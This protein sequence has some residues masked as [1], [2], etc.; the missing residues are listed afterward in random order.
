MVRSGRVRKALA[1]GVAALLTA[2]TLTLL[3]V[4]PAHAAPPLWSVGT[5]E[6]IFTMPGSG[7]VAG[8]EVACAAGWTPIAGSHQAFGTGALYR[9]SEEVGYGSGGVYSVTLK[10]G[11]NNVATDLYVRAYCVPTS[12]FSSSAVRYGVF[13]ASSGGVAAGTVACD[14][15]WYSLSARVTF[16]SFSGGPIRTSTP[17][18]EFD[19]WY[20]VGTAPAGTQMTVIVRCVPA[21][22]MSNARFASS[23]VTI[24]SNGAPASASCT[25][26]M[27]PIV[28]GT[29]QDSGS[30][31]VTTMAR[32]Y[33]PT[34]SWVSSTYGG[35]GTMRTNLVCVPGASPTV[36][37]NSGAPT[38]QPNASEASWTFSATDPAA[39]GGYS[40]STAC[41][42]D[43]GP[44]NGCASPYVATGLADGRH[45]VDV[46]ATTSDGRVSQSARGE[47]RIDTTPPSWVFTS[48]QI[49]ADSTPSVTLDVSDADPWVS[50]QC[51][52]DGA[53][54]VTC[55]GVQVWND[56][57][58][59][60]LYLP[61]PFTDGLHTL[62]VTGTDGRG[63][64]HTEQHVFTVDTVAPAVTQTGPSRPFVLST[65]VEAI[66]TATDA[67]TG[68]ASSQVTWRR[69]PYNGDFGESTVVQTSAAARSE[70]LDSQPRGSTACLS[71]RSLDLAAN[72]SEWTTERCAA[73][74]LDDRDLARSSGWRRSSVGGW[75]RGTALRS[76]TRGA[77][78]SV[79]GA[80]VA[81]AAVVARKCPSCGTIG[82]YVAGERIAKISLVASTSRRQLLVLPAL[83]GERTGTVVIKV[84]SSGKAV[85]I[86]A[87]GL[88]RV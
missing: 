23:T 63:N 78:L 71:V 43:G 1:R 49:H 85:Q 30:G 79:T 77:R 11:P 83:P 28:G 62:Q 84:L 27:V 53:D 58:A 64:S 22:D 48:P 61:T 33:L 87:L 50:F 5:V 55:G 14:P 47:V 40:I 20:T 2:L 69:A 44:Y 76:E 82:V 21:S 36:S 81:R 6:R 12:Y 19:A 41:S 29:W 3:P 56:P 32:P 15:G 42:L 57:T 60:T 25:A 4:A 66:W 39:S 31:A 68:I 52:V 75:F 37:V 59:H 35:S 51:G 74:P 13:T 16:S 80:T 86:D 18:M 65:S 10:A 7:Q 8:F 73:V 38:P 9:L 70:S 45:T 34:G 26:G 88:S 67:S 72:A 24:G 54:P 46:R 17:D